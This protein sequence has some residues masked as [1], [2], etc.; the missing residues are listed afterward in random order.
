MKNFI[1]IDTIKT[2][3]KEELEDIIIKNPFVSELI[4]KGEINGICEDTI[5]FLKD[6]SLSGNVTEY[7]KHLLL[8]KADYEWFSI[9][10]DISDKDE[11]FFE[12][13]LKANENEVDVRF[14]KKYLTESEDMLDL[15]RAREDFINGKIDEE[16]YKEII[17]PRLKNSEENIS[18]DSNAVRG[19]AED[20][21]ECEYKEA[22]MEQDNSIE[23]EKDLE[24]DNSVLMAVA[25]NQKPKQQKEAKRSLYDRLLY[26]LIGEDSIEIAESYIND[27]S[28]KKALALLNKALEGKVKTENTINKM[29]ETILS[30][31]AYIKDLELG[32]KLKDENIAALENELMETKKGKEKFEN[33]YLELTKQISAVKGCLTEG[34]A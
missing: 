21:A 15:A 25:L 23:D 27:D 26:E 33:A 31:T 29:K 22:I 2:D 30:Q 16:S 24:K 6:N 5:L 1:E 11:N 32:N 13:I 9:L 4:E 3:Y 10:F 7:A 14:A 19:E 20:L 18:E 34:H 28:I 12:E 17:F 8:N